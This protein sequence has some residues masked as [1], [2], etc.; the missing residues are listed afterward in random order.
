MGLSRRSVDTIIPAL[1]KKL[2]D[3]GCYADGSDAVAPTKPKAK[4][5]K[6][7]A[8]EAEDSGVDVESAPKK[9]KGGKKDAMTEV[10]L[11]EGL[12]EANDEF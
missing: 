6:R 5:K 10:K 3:G 2:R 8:A 7:K 4:G 11:E 1:L 12:E 9:A